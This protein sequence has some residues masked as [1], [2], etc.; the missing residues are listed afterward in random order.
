MIRRSL[1]APGEECGTT[2]VPSVGGHTVRR[3]RHSRQKVGPLL[4]QVD[5][6]LDLV[7]ISLFLLLLDT[8][9]FEVHDG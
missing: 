5:G 1:I 7:R 2:L 9:P 8:D 6:D 4:I 3:D